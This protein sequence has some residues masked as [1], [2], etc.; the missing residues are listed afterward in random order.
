MCFQMTAIKIRYRNTPLPGTHNTFP[1]EIH[2]CKN[3]CL[4]C[5]S[6]LPFLEFKFVVIFILSLL[7]HCVLDVGWDKWLVIL[8][9]R[10]QY[11]E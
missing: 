4:L 5:A 10:S 3:Q 7:H 8:D 9:C 6:I 11:Q 1:L 2:H